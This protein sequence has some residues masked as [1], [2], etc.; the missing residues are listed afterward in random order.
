MTVCGEKVDIEDF[1]GAEERVVHPKSDEQ[2]QRLS[3][4]IS[5]LLI[6]SSL[7]DV[8]L[9]LTCSPVKFF[10]LF[11]FTMNLDFSLCLLFGDVTDWVSWTGD[12]RRAERCLKQDS[13][14]PISCFFMSLFNLRMRF[15]NVFIHNSLKAE[16]A[17]LRFKLD[18]DT[19]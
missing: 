17:L 15:H 4:A 11:C 16:K 14:F 3:K 1:E 18:L 8:S 6:F 12:N 5:N 13:C 19:Q 7:D 9:T 2:R 10:K